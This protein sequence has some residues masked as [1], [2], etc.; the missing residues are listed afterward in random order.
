MKQKD[1]NNI[2][3]L[4]TLWLRS[5]RTQGSRAYLRSAD[6]RSADLG[7]ANL[8]GAYL[9]NAYLGGADLRSA[10]LTNANLGGANLTNA[11]LGGAYLANANLTN[12][13][14]QGANLRGANLRGA[15]LPHFQIPQEGELVVWKCLRTGVC[16]L[17][18]PPEARRTATL[19]GRKCRAEFVE[20]L[21]GQEGFDQH[22]GSLKYRKGTLTKPDSYDDDIR[23]ECTHGIHFFLTREE[24]KEFGNL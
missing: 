5:C 7:D 16:K 20:L 13:N 11:N 9:T 6:L 21:E 15:N 12:A 8:R 4:H 22:S 1:L 10:D 2:L 24:A 18:V 17:R 14:L 23:V 19:V 3:E